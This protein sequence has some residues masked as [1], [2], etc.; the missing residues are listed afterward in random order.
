[1]TTRIFE[2]LVKGF[3]ELRRVGVQPVSIAMSQGTKEQLIQE[4]GLNSFPEHKYDTVDGVRIEIIKQKT[5]KGI[6]K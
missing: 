5:R 4:L 3:S 2:S 6:I 1:M